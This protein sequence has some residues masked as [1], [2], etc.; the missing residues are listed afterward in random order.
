MKYSVFSM[1]FTNISKIILMMAFCAP[2][3]QVFA[4]DPCSNVP[5]SNNVRGAYQNESVSEDI[6]EYFKKVAEKSG[7]DH[8]KYLEKTN[9]LV[10]FAHPRAF[11]D[12]IIFIMSIVTAGGCAFFEKLAYEMYNHSSDEKGISIFIGSMGLIFGGITV[13]LWF[14]IYKNYKM[15]NGFVPYLTFDSMGLRKFNESVL[16]WKNVY[17]IKSDV[18]YKTNLEYVGDHYENRTKVE[19]VTLLFDKYGEVLFR[20]SDGDDFLPVNYNST[21]IVLNHC[22]A[23]FGDDKFKV[24]Q[25]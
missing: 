6:N 8:V 19:H 4:G 3:I 7:S 12:F 10:F 24:A 17:S 18:I 23:D 2:S 14:W 11:V 20:L 21:V 5:V 25:H 15:R 22:L 13:A 16:E 9:K 1:N